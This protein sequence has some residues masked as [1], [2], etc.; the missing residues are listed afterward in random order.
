MYCIHSQWMNN[1]V[2]GRCS[3][4]I[5]FQ[6][7]HPPEQASMFPDALFQLQECLILSIVYPEIDGYL[8]RW[9]GTE[10]MNGSLFVATNSRFL[11]IL[12]LK[13][14]IM[15]P[16]FVTFI[17][18]MWFHY[19]FSWESLKTRLSTMCSGWQRSSVSVYIGTISLS[20]AIC[21]LFDM[22]I[23]SL[24]LKISIADTREIARRGLIIWSVICIPIFLFHV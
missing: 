8:D 21:L 5:Q 19:L 24:F 14:V 20:L 7:N 22:M 9:R 18:R 16:T 1:I 4:N 2:I 3:K 23:N 12:I 11:S 6:L 10:W 15:D 17:H 13:S